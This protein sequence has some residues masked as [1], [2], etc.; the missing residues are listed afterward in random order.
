MDVLLMGIFGRYV[1]RSK[2]EG[3]NLAVNLSNHCVFRKRF[4]ITVISLLALGNNERLGE[5][6]LERTTQIVMPS[7]LNISGA[8]NYLLILRGVIDVRLFLV[9]N[10]H[11]IQVR[12]VTER[13][14][15]DLT[16]F[17]LSNPSYVIGIACRDV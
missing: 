13:D 12:A 8:R 9:V 17:I 1:E 4:E 6:F 14:V 5:H 11:Y 7:V 10:L 3:L 2:N 15:K 16:L